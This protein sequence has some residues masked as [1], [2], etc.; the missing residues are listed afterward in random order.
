VN[1]KLEKLDFDFLLRYLDKNV[2]SLEN[3]V[4]AISGASGFVGSW[5]VESLI[6][7]DSEFR[8]GLNLL[9]LTR[10]T[11]NLNYVKAYAGYP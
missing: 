1:R 11:Q 5:L 6:K 2:K 8:L 9:L 7:L 10:N 4:I 3:A